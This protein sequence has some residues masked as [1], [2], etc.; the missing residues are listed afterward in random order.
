[1]KSI[2]QSE[3]VCY[4]TGRTD[5]LERHHIFYGRGIR[6]LSEKYGLTV[7]LNHYAHNEPPMGVH[8]NKEADL[9]LKRAGQKAFEKH[10]PNLDFLIIFGRNYL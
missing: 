2:L 7:Y 6:P 4:L 9:A 8:H 1:M 3:K 5:W 10:Y